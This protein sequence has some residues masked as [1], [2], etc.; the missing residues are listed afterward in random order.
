MS[1]S[2]SIALSPDSADVRVRPERCPLA[3]R[4]HRGSMGLFPVKTKNRLL[5]IELKTI[6]PVRLDIVMSIGD[7]HEYAAESF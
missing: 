7:N 6:T 4:K 2:R 5:I 3:A 1:D